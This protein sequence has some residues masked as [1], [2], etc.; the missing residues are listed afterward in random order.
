MI[1]RSCTFASFLLFVGAATAQ[2]EGTAQDSPTAVLADCGSAELS[3]S[4]VDSCLERARVLDETD[5]SPQ[6]QSLE[7]QLE[8]RETGHRAVRRD[9]RPL[10]PSSAPADSDPGP[11]APEPTVVESERSLPP[12]AAEPD[13]DR[14][15]ASDTPASPAPEERGRDDEQRSINLGADRP[16]PGINDDQPPVTDP[17]DSESPRD[18]DSDPPNDSR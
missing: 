11:H 5:P 4:Q 10:Q 6:L 2:A 18:Q 14:S 16:P 8:Q 7:A 12:A 3:N 17:P 13:Q 9:P 15:A 1:W